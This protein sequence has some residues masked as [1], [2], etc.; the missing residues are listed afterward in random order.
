[1]NNSSLRTALLLILVSISLFASWQGVASSYAA[2]DNYGYIGLSSLLEPPPDEAVPV[3]APEPGSSLPPEGIAAAAD[4]SR[5]ALSV[6]HALP[7]TLNAPDVAPVLVAVLDTGIDK[8][9]PDLAGRV[10]AEVDL[11]RSGSPADVFGHGTPIAGIIAANAENDLGI[12]GLAPESRLVNIK[13]ADDSGRCQISR[14]ID[15]IYRAVDAGAKVIN[16]SIQFSE[17]APGL[18]EAVNYAW[19]NGAVIIAAAGNDGSAAPVYPA[20]YENCIAVT[21]VQENGAL[22]PL[23]NHGDWVDVAAPGLDIYSTL[24]GDSYGYKHGTSFAA[25]YVSG[26]ASLLFTFAADTN[27]DGNLNDEVRRA[28]EAGCDVIDIDGTGKG[29]INVALS[30]AELLLDIG[31][32]G[33]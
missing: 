32:A 22:A 4:K 12:A 10:V 21:A 5:W 29:R 25:A 33:D 17:T 16:I 27:G 24:P 9:H 2:S 13:V 3:L 18:E 6:I 20:S 11:S 28:I 14:L 19:N 15:G 7:S 30:V 23:A 8:G 31:S 26:L 1:M